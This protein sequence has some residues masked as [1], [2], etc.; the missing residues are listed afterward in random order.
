MSKFSLI[1]LA[2]LSLLLL[3]FGRFGFCKII[4]A[5][6]NN[7][8]FNFEDCDTI[9]AKGVKTF[10]DYTTENGKTVKGFMYPS[11]EFEAACTE[12]TGGRYIL[13]APFS[14]FRNEKSRPISRKNLKKR[15]IK[16]GI[17]R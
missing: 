3:L 4:S 2:L 10:Q 5:T 14:T 8:K 17:K 11:N 15:G 1:R 7:K 12:G 9:A 13:R 16:T 6:I